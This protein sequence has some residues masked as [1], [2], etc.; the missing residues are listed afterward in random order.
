MQSVH[1]QVETIK[2][3]KRS[4]SHSFSLAQGS[5]GFTLDWFVSLFD[6]SIPLE[7]VF[8]LITSGLIG[9]MGFITL[10]WTV[11]DP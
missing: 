9:T 6:F 10:V 7:Q 4:D 8:S 5:P 3:G 11:G 2:G 1:W